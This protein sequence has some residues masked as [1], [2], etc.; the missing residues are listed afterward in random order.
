MP[1]IAFQEVTDGNDELAKWCK[2]RKSLSCFC[3]KSSDPGVQKRYQDIAE[4]VYSKYKYHQAA[5]F[6]KGADGWIIAHALETHGFVVS[7]E[8]SRSYR[9][10]IKIPTIAKLFNAPL[11]STSDMCRDLGGKFS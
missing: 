4:H 3:V 11:K 9:A 1:R 10:K 7:S 8:S 6:L 5:E 2:D